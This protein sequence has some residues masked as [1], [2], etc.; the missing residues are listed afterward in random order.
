MRNEGS[1]MNKVKIKTKKNQK[2][3]NEKKWNG[4]KYVC[5]V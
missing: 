3:K 5:I 1:G 2:L 4:N